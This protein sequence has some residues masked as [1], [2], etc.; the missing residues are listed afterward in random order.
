MR[1]R[2][3]RACDSW[4]PCHHLTAHLVRACQPLSLLLPLPSLWSS[5]SLMA[6]SSLLK[7]KYVTLLPQHPT[8]SHQTWGRSWSMQSRLGPLGFPFLCYAHLFILLL[9]HGLPCWSSNIQGKAPTSGSLH[10]LFPRPGALPLPPHIPTPLSLVSFESLLRGHLL[11][12]P[13]SEAVLKN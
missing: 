1:E 13:S 12:R 3:K 2:E 9:T 6:I 10:W 4:K 11:K 7:P 8:A 5:F